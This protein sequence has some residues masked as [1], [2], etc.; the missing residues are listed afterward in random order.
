MLL[1]AGFI[2]KSL[3]MSLRVSI[4]KRE[5]A[6]STCTELPLITTEL[7]REDMIL[8]L[9][10]KKVEYQIN[11]GERQNFTSS[12]WK[13]RSRISQGETEYRGKEISLHSHR[14]CCIYYLL[15]CLTRKV[16]V[17]CGIKKGM[18][19]SLPISNN[20]YQ[21]CILELETF[22]HEMENKLFKV[23]EELV[24][25]LNFFLMFQL[26]ESEDFLSWFEIILWVY[27]RSKNCLLFLFEK[28]LQIGVFPCWRYQL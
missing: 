9:W 20:L 10:N 25:L 18:E 19:K 17:K 1:L 23:E 8:N 12:R 11:Q 22:C 14:T 6:G 16:S 21:F 7:T 28:I 26:G 13:Q 3:F 24:C 4:L 15:F 5:T 2:S 27:N